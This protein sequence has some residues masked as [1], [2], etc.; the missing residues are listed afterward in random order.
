MET[1][2]KPRRI[3]K[4]VVYNVD[5]ASY[6]LDSGLVEAIQTWIRGRLEQ[7]TFVMPRLP[8]AAVRI[9][10]ISQD[11]DADL[12]DITQ[13]VSTDPGLAARLLGIANSAAYAGSA[14]VQGL[15][16]ALSRLGMKTVSNLVFAESLQSKVFSVRD[17]RSLLEPS[18]QVSLGAAVAC[19]QL[20]RVTGIEPEGA[21]L[22]GLLHDVGVPALVNAVTE[23]SRQNLGRALEE[24]VVE[25]LITQLH[26]ETGA[27][28]LRE[29]GMPAA[30]VAAA[31]SHH[32]Y[33][34]QADTPPAC[35]LI[36]AAVR[37]GE[38]LGVGG[39]PRE[40]NFTI[41][42]AFRD[43]G[44]NDLQKMEPLLEAVSGQIAGLMSGFAAKATAPDVDPGRRRAA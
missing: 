6:G 8:Q 44:L 12:G 7:G 4:N 1:P 19:E 18:W 21:F 33:R 25:I 5:G 42:H 2:G 40:V 32:L 24:E 9:L 20:A 22:I 27:C 36:H 30:A 26:E 3:P 17:H 31:G 10:Q 34:S 29:W 13:V 23:L 14:P 15:G 28:V 37:I 16:P 35:R 41:D 11:A 43:F 39:E 38:H